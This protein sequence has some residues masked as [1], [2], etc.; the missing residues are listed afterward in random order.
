MLLALVTLCPFG[1]VLYLL[2]LVGS[3]WNILIPYGTFGTHYASWYFLGEMYDSNALQNA[4]F[5][6]WSIPT[7]VCRG[8]RGASTYGP[9]S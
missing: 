5:A 7:L 4:I 9:V 3:I 6:W 2:V 1:L 8:T